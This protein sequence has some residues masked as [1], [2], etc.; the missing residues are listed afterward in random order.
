MLTN[1][2]VSFEQPGR[3]CSESNSLKGKNMA[4]KASLLKTKDIFREQYITGIHQTQL[5][6][7]CKYFA[8]FT[9]Q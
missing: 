4:F 6:H 5:F 8:I 1:D 7:A 3:G 2:V 9:C